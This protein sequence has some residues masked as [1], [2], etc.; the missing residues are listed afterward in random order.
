MV[1]VGASL[2]A[3]GTVFCAALL[4]ASAASAVGDPAAGEKIFNKCKTCHQI[5][6]GAR[7]GVGPEQNGIDGRKAGVQPNYSYSEANKNSGITW[8]HDTFVKYL[9]NPKAMIPGTKMVFPGL[10]AEKD[11]EDLW[12]YMAQFK[13]DG[14][15][16]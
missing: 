1:R 8:N 5:G 4:S 10:P 15:K 13:E 3:A 14:S 16:K 9:E 6:P 7:N 12:S 11:R 2:V